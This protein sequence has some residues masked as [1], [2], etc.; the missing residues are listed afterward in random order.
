MNVM[1]FDVTFCQIR[2]SCGAHADKHCM[3]VSF[4]LKEAFHFSESRRLMGQK[5]RTRTEKT[6]II[7]Y[8]L[9]TMYNC[10]SHADVRLG[11]ICHTI[12]LNQ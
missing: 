2:D 10:R 11:S 7:H 9:T 8:K 12:Y 6:L 5:A 1:E 4:L 3:S